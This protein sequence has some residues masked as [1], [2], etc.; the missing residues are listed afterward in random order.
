MEAIHQN[1]FLIVNPSSTCAALVV[2]LDFMGFSGF[3]GGG[4]ARFHGG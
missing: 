1:G 4:L 3:H 2:W